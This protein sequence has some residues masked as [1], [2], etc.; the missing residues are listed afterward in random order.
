MIISASVLQELLKQITDLCT[1]SKWNKQRRDHFFSLDVRLNAQPEKDGERDMERERDRDRET[2][3]CEWILLLPRNEYQ[4]YTP[5]EQWVSTVG[6]GGEAGSWHRHEPRGKCTV[7]SSHCIQSLRGWIIPI[8]GIG[9]PSWQRTIV[10]EMINQHCSPAKEGKMCI[11][12]L[13][14]YQ[15][16]LDKSLQYLMH[17]SQEKGRD[18]PRTPSHGV[19]VFVISTLSVS[20]RRN[21]A[22]T[23]FGL[24]VPTS[25]CPLV[26]NTCRNSKTLKDPPFK[27]G[28]PFKI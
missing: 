22:V 5:T 21:I 12:I 23:C 18:T 19:C 17:K 4:N 13:Y 26:H 6:H 14:P 16:L 10:S 28:L 24:C 15:H 9:S 27:N 25:A 7:H 20:V 8:R 3:K 2:G 1:L 11:L